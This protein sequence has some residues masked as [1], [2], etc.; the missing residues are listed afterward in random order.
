MSP[1]TNHRTLALYALLACVVVGVTIKVWLPAHRHM[2]Q[3]RTELQQKQ[4]YLAASSGLQKAVEA[5]Y[6]ELD[7]T[8]SYLRTWRESSK[9]TEDLARFFGRVHD[10][11]RSAGVS[12][13]GF[14]PEAAVAYERVRQTPLQLSCLGT[15]DQI[16]AFLYALERTPVLI[17]IDHVQIEQSGETGKPLRCQIKLV[18]FA[19][20]SDETDEVNAAGAA[21]G[22]PPEAPSTAQPSVAA[23]LLEANGPARAPNGA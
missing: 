16:A 8:Q 2:A 11:A 18:I 21:A 4:Q 22:A 1:L 6:A 20:Y 13:T 19:V 9:A 17:R 12:T 15:F 7:R 14:S 10:L 23:G 5:E 3:L